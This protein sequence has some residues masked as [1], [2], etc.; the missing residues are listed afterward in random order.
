MAHR[1]ARRVRRSR[2]A[3]TLQ[4]F[5]ALT[6]GP[7]DGEVD[8]LRPIYLEHK[9]RFGSDSWAVRFYEHGIDDRP[10]DDRDAAEVD[11]TDA[12]LPGTDAYRQRVAADVA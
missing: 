7:A 2:H 10:R 12:V 8:A 9:E 6:L 5:M 1:R 11:D 4:M 3:L